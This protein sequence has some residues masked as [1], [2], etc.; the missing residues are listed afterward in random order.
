MRPTDTASAPLVRWLRHQQ[1]HLLLGA[2]LVVLSALLFWWAWFFHSTI[3]EE[4][5]RNHKNLTLLAQ[6]AAYKLGAQGQKTPP[7]VGVYLWDSRLEI[8]RGTRGAGVVPLSPRWKHLGVR[9]RPAVVKRLQRKYRR[10][11]TMLTGEGLFLALCMLIFSILLYRSLLQERRSKEELKEFWS[12]I[13]HE[14]K[15]PITG[16][17]AFLETLKRREFSRQELLPLLDLAM[18]QIQR[19]ELLATHLLRGQQMESSSFRIELSPLEWTP[20]VEGFFAE[21]DLQLTDGQVSLELLPAGES[22]VQG[23]PSV[24]REILNNLTD[25]ALKYSEKTLQLQV[26][27]EENKDF[28][29]VKVTDNG[30]GFPPAMAERLFESYRYLSQSLPQGSSGTGMGLYLSRKLARRMGGELKAFS[31]GQEQG[32]TFS[33]SLRKAPS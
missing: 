19:Q 31:P 15:T 33:L 16:L 1:H 29:V 25:N 23:N 24:I 14:I 4:Y 3:R 17:K 7:H 10:R 11:V 22:R 28:L 2:M 12:R 18:S 30:K 6:I 5:H 21:D 32:A 9:L 13:T 26:K 27:M 20:L 8:V